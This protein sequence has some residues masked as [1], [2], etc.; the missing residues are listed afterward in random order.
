MGASAQNELQGSLPPASVKTKV[1]GSPQPQ[2]GAGRADKESLQGDAAPA[3]NTGSRPWNFAT[4]DTSLQ[5]PRS[6][7]SAGPQSDCTSLSPPSQSTSRKGR[8]SPHETA[9]LNRFEA[10]RCRLHRRGPD[11]PG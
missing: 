8:C 6:C 5:S 1:G 11:L 7:I 4:S 3:L 9:R 10:A 2:L